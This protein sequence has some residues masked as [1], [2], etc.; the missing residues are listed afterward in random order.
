MSRHYHCLWLIGFVLLIGA[1]VE[2][3]RID[4]VAIQSQAMDTS[5]NAIVVTPASY[6]D[7]EMQYPVVYILHGW[8]GSFIDWQK[9][10]DLRPLADEYNYILVCPDGGYAGW[11][12]DSEETDS[13]QYETYIGTEVPDYLDT[14]YRT[15]SRTEGRGIVGLSMGGY[16]AISLLAR[17]PDR[18]IAGGSMSGVMVFEPPKWDNG[19]TAVLG[20]PGEFPELW[21]NESAITLI[22][23]LADKSRGILIDCGISDHL[24]ESNREIHT[25]LMELGIPHDYYERPGKHSWDYWTRVLPYHLLYLQEWMTPPE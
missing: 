2:G 25:R 21:E 11:Y 22:E 16:G 10:M 12:I 23:N 1:P 8:S 18:Y 9:H 13:L 15:I 17:Y 7:T 14:H 3:A 5:Y 19:L 6:Y 24:I 4:T 20:S